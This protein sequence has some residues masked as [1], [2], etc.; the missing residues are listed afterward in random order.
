MIQPTIGVRNDDHTTLQRQIAAD[1]LTDDVLNPYNNMTLIA[2]HFAAPGI[3]LGYEGMHWMSIHASVFSN[4]SLNQNAVT[5]NSQSDIAYSARIM[6]WPRFFENSLNTYIGASY[7]QN[8][9]VKV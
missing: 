5:Y 8:G 4:T 7:L 6:F 1:W 3:E 2:P 9:D